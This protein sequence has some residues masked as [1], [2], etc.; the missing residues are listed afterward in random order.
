[1]LQTDLNGLTA[2][3]LL[4][5]IRSTNKV[6]DVRF[7]VKDILTQDW[8]QIGKVEIMVRRNN[9]LVSGKGLLLRELGQMCQVLRR[10]N[11]RERNAY[12]CSATRKANRITSLEAF[13]E[14]QRNKSGRGKTSLR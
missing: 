14:S 10:L 6:N 5:K 11:D 7:I 9:H 3:D 13:R 8:E 12:V 1:M 2:D 4:S